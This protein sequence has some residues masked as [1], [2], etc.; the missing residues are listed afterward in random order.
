MRCNFKL[1]EDNMNANANKC[2]FLLTNN[3]SFTV[4]IDQSKTP[5]TKCV[6]LLEIKF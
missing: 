2:Y 5:E 4:K 1:L 6:T 3:E